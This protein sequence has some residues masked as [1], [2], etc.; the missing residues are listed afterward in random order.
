M[1]RLFVL[2]FLT[3]VTVLAQKTD[4]SSAPR[5]DL[6]RDPFRQITNE[7]WVVSFDLR[8]LFI[9]FETRQGIRPLGDWKRLT[10]T[11]MDPS[12]N[13]L[14]AFNALDNKVIFL[15]NYPFFVPKKSTIDVFAV[16]LGEV[17][18]YK[19]AKGAEQTAP[20]YDYGFPYNPIAEMEA[21]A[22]AQASI[23]K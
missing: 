19:D 9:W 8:P 23:V 11:T 17:H 12:G 18:K 10:V 16:T 5:A 2:L 3:T 15:K 4:D 14:L 1:K 7:H 22:K 21:A 20:V 13:G 6:C